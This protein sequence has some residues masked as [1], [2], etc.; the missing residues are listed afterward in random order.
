MSE[1][2]TWVNGPNLA[3]SGFESGK[4]Q[5]P[6]RYRPPLLML[7]VLFRIMFARPFDVLR[8]VDHV[9]VGDDC[10][11]SRHFEISRPV[12]LGGE[13]MVFCGM[14]QQFRSL[15]MMINALLRHC[16][17]LPYRLSIG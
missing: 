13:T 17:N 14:L 10:M 15:Q 8:R 5:V 6:P 2:K 3:V 7:I 4:R 11:M 16:A 1:I 9:A 12:V